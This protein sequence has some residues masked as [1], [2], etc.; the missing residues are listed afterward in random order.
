MEGAAK[1]V[2]TAEDGT[3]YHILHKGAG[4]DLVDYISADVE[5]EGV[6]YPL[7]ATAEVE[8][9]EEK[10]FLLTVRRYQLIDGY[11][12]PWYDDNA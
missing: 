5:V 8:G 6:A 7:A 10:A 3:Q 11:D 4:M 9:E 2:V 12:D 1:V